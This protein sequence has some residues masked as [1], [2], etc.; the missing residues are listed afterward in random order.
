[1]SHIYRCIPINM[2][3]ISYWDVFPCSLV[4]VYAWSDFFIGTAEDPSLRFFAMN[5]GKDQILG[6]VFGGDFFGF[7]PTESLTVSALSG[8]SARS[9][10]F[11]LLLEVVYW[12]SGLKFMYP[13]KNLAFLGIIVKVK[14]PAKFCMHSF[15]W[16]C[17][18]IDC[19][20]KYFFHSCP[21]HCDRGLIKFL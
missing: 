16:F 6:N 8:L 14:L 17:L 18:Q 2:I 3:M 13:M 15:E 21:R 9:G 4:K 1:M 19:D 7:L 11:C 20:T 5:H 12:P 10:I